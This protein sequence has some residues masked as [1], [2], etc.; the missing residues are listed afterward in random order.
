MQVKYTQREIALKTAWHFWGEWYTW[1]GDN[2][3]GF[4]C[5]G[6][7]IECLK[8]AGCLPRKG[9]WTAANLHERYKYKT[10]KWPKAGTLVFYRSTRTGEVC[11]VEMMIDDKR[12]IGASGG[13]A[14]VRNIDDAIAANAFIKI[15]PLNIQNKPIYIEPYEGEPA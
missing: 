13:G 10:T 14:H 1:G 5:S 12:T 11:H 6:L 8:S 9:D 4:D 7:I 15:R 2:P 3:A